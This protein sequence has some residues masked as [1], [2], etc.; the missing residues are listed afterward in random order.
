MSATFVL[1]VTFTSAAAFSAA[2]AASEVVATRS[3]ASVAVVAF[4]E[5]GS[6]VNS[7]LVCLPTAGIFKLVMFI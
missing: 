7:R 3:A 2:A 4:R 5:T 6:Q 1:V